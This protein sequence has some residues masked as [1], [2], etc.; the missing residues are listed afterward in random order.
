MSTAQRQ[1]IPRAKLPK[2][3][4]KTAMTI[5]R[6]ERDPALAFPVPIII[7]GLRYY[8]LAELEAWEEARREPDA[9]NETEAA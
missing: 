6:W 2:R 8:D 1:L 3:Y 7:N 5:H 4:S 9:S